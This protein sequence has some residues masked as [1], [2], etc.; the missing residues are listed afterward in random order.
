MQGAE[1]TLQ[2]LFVILKKGLSFDIVIIIH[3][4]KLVK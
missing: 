4:K 2:S 3:L 1:H